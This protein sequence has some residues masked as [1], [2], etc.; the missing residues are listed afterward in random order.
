[1]LG[2]EQV[3]W[4]R[5]HH[6]RPDGLGYPHGLR[7]GAIPEGAALLSVADA[8]DVMTFSRPYAKTKAPAE[9]LGECRDLVGR[10]FS[11]AAIAALL[12]VHAQDALPPVSTPTDQA[13][14]QAVV[15]ARPA[16]A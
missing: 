10:Q 5:A 7:E 14:W 13:G 4:I 12:T 15:R 6:E 8:W 16:V 1:M 9:A 2:A 11:E 3:A